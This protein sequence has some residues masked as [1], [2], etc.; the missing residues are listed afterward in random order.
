M[1][2]GLQESGLCA[3]YRAML[4]NRYNQNLKSIAEI[5]QKDAER[6]WWAA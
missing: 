6:G 3:E 4:Q 1:G 5:K 2:L